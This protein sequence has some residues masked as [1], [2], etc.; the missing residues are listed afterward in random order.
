M[1]AFVASALVQRLM[2]FDRGATDDLQPA[3]DLEDGCVSWINLSAGAWTGKVV[4]DARGPAEY[5]E[6]CRAFVFE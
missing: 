5:R 1:L 4:S 6:R 3:R 2:C